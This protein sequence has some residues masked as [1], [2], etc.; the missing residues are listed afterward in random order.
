MHPSLSHTLSVCDHFIPSHIPSKTVPHPTEF[1]I[2]LVLQEQSTMLCY[3]NSHDILPSAPLSQ[4]T[5]PYTAYQMLKYPER[6]TNGLNTLKPTHFYTYAYQHTGAFPSTNTEQ[7]KCKY[8]YGTFFNTGRKVLHI[9][10]GTEEKLHKMSTYKATI[11][12]EA[13]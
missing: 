2:Q 5:A 12:Q 11:T 8:F 9:N 6:N 13:T 7:V 4:V 3:S 10:N 1:A